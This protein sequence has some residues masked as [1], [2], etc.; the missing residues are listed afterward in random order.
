MARAKE[1]DVEEWYK[2]IEEVLEPD[3]NALSEI[4][5]HKVIAILANEKMNLDQNQKS[6]EFFEQLMKYL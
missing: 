2:T 6:V 5:R 4:S 1:G 3:I